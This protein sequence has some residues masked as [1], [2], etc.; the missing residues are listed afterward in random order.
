VGRTL[1][2]ELLQRARHAGVASVMLEVRDS[3][4]PARALYESSGFQAIARRAEYYHDP[5]EDAVIYRIITRIKIVTGANVMN[6]VIRQISP[7]SSEANRFFS[8]TPECH[9]SQ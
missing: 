3:N 6:V 9:V 8:L 5:P 2:A 7:C 4:Q 1:V